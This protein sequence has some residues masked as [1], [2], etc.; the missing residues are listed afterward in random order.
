VFK[1]ARHVN[2]PEKERITQAFVKFG[3][4]ASRDERAIEGVISY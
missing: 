2:G 4:K 1:Y 3:N